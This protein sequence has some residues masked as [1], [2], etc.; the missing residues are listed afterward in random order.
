MAFPQ[1]RLRRLRRT[2]ALGRL[3]GETQMSVGSLIDPL[4]VV[5]G[6]RRSTNGRRAPREE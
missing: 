6:D 1:T 3:V 4:F 5:P 2:E